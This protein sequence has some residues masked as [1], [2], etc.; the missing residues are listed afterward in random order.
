MLFAFFHMIEAFLFILY[1]L[2]IQLFVWISNKKDNTDYNE[3]RKLQGSG[4]SC[5]S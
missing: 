2:C 4:N 1:V 3:F 5:C